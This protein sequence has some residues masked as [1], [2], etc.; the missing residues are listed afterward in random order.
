MAAQASAK[1]NFF[2]WKGTDSRGSPQKG[3][4]P[5]PNIAIVK[6]QLR[7]QGIRVDKINRKTARLFES[8]KPKINPM[9]IVIIT[10]QLA[11][12]MKSG[13]PLVQSIEIVGEG[14][15]NASMR[16]FVFA[17]RDEVSDGNNFADS[18]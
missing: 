3:E 17:I 1:Q 2:Q 18:I 12:M 6:V 14:L 7:K 4:M 8:S 16:L 5:G 10:W 15:E 11:T 13:I 9:N